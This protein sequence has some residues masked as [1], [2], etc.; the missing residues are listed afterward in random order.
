MTASDLL[1]LG[2]LVFALIGITLCIIGTIRGNFTG[3]LLNRTWW[4]AVLSMLQALTLLAL[5]ELLSGPA[6]IFFWTFNGFYLLLG[7]AGSIVVYR[8]FRAA[9]W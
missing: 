5:R 2:Y 7:I 9:S 3:S 1:G 8:H 6:T 4:L